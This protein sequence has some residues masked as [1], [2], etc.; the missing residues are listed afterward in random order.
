MAVGEVRELVQDEAGKSSKSLVGRWR[1]LLTAA[2]GIL[3]VVELALESIITVLAEI[4]RRRAGGT[5]DD[6]TR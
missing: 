5:E 3:T 4:E 1:V 2:C 6:H